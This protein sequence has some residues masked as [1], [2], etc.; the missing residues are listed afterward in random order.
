V[1]NVVSRLEH[2]AT[3]TPDG[4][5]YGFLD[6]AGEIAESCTYRSFHERTNRIAASLAENGKVVFGEPVLLLYPPGIDFILAFMACAKLGALP[7][8]V[9]PPE[10]SGFA[11][12]LEKLALLM[13]DSGACVALTS[14]AHLRQ[15]RGLAE[16]RQAAAPLLTQPPLGTLDWVTTDDMEGTLSEFAATPGELLFL[17]YTSGST[18]SP[19]GVM[20]SHANV[21]HNCRATLQHRPIGVAWLP[22]YHDMGLIG[23]FLF[24]ML[25][26]GEAYWFSGAAFLR[27]P[28]LWLEAMSRY[29]STITSAPNSAF[30]Y[31]LR[32]DRIPIDRLVGLDLRSVRCMMNASEPVRSDT[33]DRFIARLAPCGLTPRAM[34][35]WYGLAENTLSVTGDG[36]VQLTVNKHLLEQNMLR[37]E[38]PR[39]DRVNQARL[40]SC[41]RPLEGINVRIVDSET[42]RDLGSD[43]TGEIWVGGGSK[44]RGYW[45][46]PSTSEALLA[47]KI[48]DDPTGTPYLRT[49]DI[50]F[51]HDGELFVCGRSKDIVIIG[52]RNYYPSDIEAV[53]ER[54]SPLLR[55]GCI[56]AF[57]IE[58]AAGGEGVAVLAEAVRPNDLPDLAALSREVRRHCHIE[59]DMLAIVPHGAVVKTSSGKV[60]RQLCR[61]RWTDGEVP[62]LA[63]RRRTTAAQH[64][65]S[66]EA[67]LEAYDLAADGERTLAELDID[68][69]SLVELSFRIEETLQRRRGLDE[70]TK[71]VLFDL[72]LLQAVTLRELHGFVADSAMTIAPRRYARRLRAIDR[73]ERWMMQRDTR[74]P[75][76]IV[77]PHA[78]SGDGR[79]LLTGATGFLGAFMLAAL[80]RVTDRNIVTILRAEDPEHAAARTVAALERTDLFDSTLRREFARRV[81]ALPGDLARPRL[82]LTLRQWAGLTEDVTSIY[83]CGAE[84]DYVKPYRWLRDVNVGGTLEL[85]RLASIGRAKEVHHVSTTFIFG[86]AP[87]LECREDESNAE[88]A[89]LNFGYAQTKWVAER[90]VAAAAERGFAVRCYR[91]SLVTASARG[92][93]VRGDLTARLLAYMI[94]HGVSVDVKN[95]ISLLPADVCANN[96]VALSLLHDPGSTVFHLTADRYYTMQDVC[97]QISRN[98][99]YGFNYLSLPDFIRHMNANC[100]KADPLYPLMAF[101]NQNHKRIERMRDKRY[102]SG[103]YRRARLLSC[104]TAAEPD[105]AD[106]VGGIVAF[107]ADE[108]LIPPAPLAERAQQFGQRPLIRQGAET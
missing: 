3:R 18:Q 90:L 45:R 99:G 76:D 5:L 44:A 70:Q 16:R 74:L 101:F 56:A 61:K 62:V 27:R 46:N 75:D 97:G 91:P 71:E 94:T 37:I 58:R 108:H 66:L 53:L 54:S 26:G 43:R 107:L 93:Y 96:I 7:V 40:V 92:R 104:H 49:G 69:L 85:L 105:L 47:G 1:D 50:G 88:M 24:I 41:G 52:G 98:F 72:R 12:S 95:Q 28:L 21:L 87:R 63:E 79:I 106:T 31:C 30:E 84:V 102:D 23:Y 11:G 34:Q 29:R 77:P 39:G 60:A 38:T 67:L 73:D 32:E 59:P 15:L 65:G 64:D 10:A 86:F 22:H 35:A 19:R 13:A 36:H 51:L 100:T 2:W 103:N 33:Q 42:R 81:V 4:L 68:S 83:H 8:P 17:Q 20:V 80:L 89:E 6:S 78:S 57:A 9:A 82:G 55:Q 25:A 48:A 14:R